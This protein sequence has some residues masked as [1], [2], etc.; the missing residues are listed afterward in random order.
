MIGDTPFESTDMTNMSSISTSDH[1]VAFS[2][3]TQNYCVGLV[4][5]VNTTKI[6]AIIGNR[7]ISHYYQIFLNLMPKTLSRFGGDLFSMVKRFDDYKFKKVKG[8]NLGFKHAYP[9][10]SVGRK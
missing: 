8:T 4:D 5:M 9:I 6:T 3:N 2:G 7:K 1:L 10:Y